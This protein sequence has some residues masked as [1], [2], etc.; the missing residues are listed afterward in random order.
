MSAALV[1]GLLGLD[2]FAV[3]GMADVDG[4]LELLVETTA[5]LVGCPVCGAV[6]RAKDRRPSWVRDLPLAGRPVVLCWWKRVWCCPHELCEAKT[7][8][9]TH[10]GIAP[11]ATLTERARQWAFEE[12]GERDA[13][14]ARVAEQLGVAWWTVMVQVIERGTAVVDDP[15]WLDP[16]GDA[17]TAAG[18]DETAFLRATGTHP[19]MYATGIA[20]LTPG[21]PARL[22]DVV[23]GRSGAVLGAWLAEQSPAW[24]AG[25]ATAS[26][27]PF[28]WVSGWR[29][30]MGRHPGGAC[31][32]R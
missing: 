19:T 9:E 16:A 24:R 4:E 7:W 10:P 26:L 11:R 30:L 25:I 23:Q 22:L 20:D 32:V 13:A 1:A 12:V 29:W 18:V 21:R 2:G 27:D 5:D 15:A 14:V 8:T 6:A 3:V 28:R 17:V 31:V